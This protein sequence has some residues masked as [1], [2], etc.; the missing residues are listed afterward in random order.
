VLEVCVRVELG[1]V[2]GALRLAQ[3]IARDESLRSRITSKGGR[4][5]VTAADVAVE[6]AVRLEL[7]RDFPS[8]PLVGEE[9][10]GTA[11]ADG[12]PYWLLDPICGTRAFASGLPLYCVNLALVDEDQ[13]VLSGVAEG[14]AEG[15]VYVAERSGGAWQ[16]R[17][18]GFTRIQVSDASPIVCCDANGTRA[19]AWTPHAA[20]FLA[21][22]LER[23]EWYVWMLPTTLPYAYLATGRISAVVQFGASSPVHFAAGCLLAAEAGATVTDLEG[24]PWSV[25]STGLV[26]AA[27]P[28][29]HA[30]LLALVAETR[31]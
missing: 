17:S 15:A 12:R 26:A 21:E 9:R 7:Q 8:Y 31:G 2:V 29:L 24:R 27:M 1:A 18:D 28:A 23:D 22:A 3:G 20:R 30:P 14:G 10:G 19:G 4:D 11:A 13:V 6:D 16:H 5:L 25:G